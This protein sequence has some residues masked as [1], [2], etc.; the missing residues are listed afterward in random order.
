MLKKKHLICSLTMS[1][2][3]MG[4][5]N[6]RTW[7]HPNPLLSPDHLLPSPVVCRS[8]PRP[9]IQVA[10]WWFDSTF[11]S[12][13]FVF[14]SPEIRRS[15]RGFQVAW[16]PS[17]TCLQLWDTETPS[18]RVGKKSGKFPPQWFYRIFCILPLHLAEGPVY[19]VVPARLPKSHCLSHASCDIMDSAWIYN[20][21]LIL[22]DYPFRWN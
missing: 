16:R 5:A 9:Q 7:R 12:K 15:T 18:W 21:Y 2:R 22:S 1:Y 3:S 20:M 4:T 17:G 6:Y 8:L 10:I 14:H 11:L 13:C 19:G